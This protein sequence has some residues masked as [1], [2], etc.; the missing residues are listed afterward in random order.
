MFKISFVSTVSTLIFLCTLNLA[1]AEPIEQRFLNKGVTAKVGGYRPLRAEMDADPELAKKLPEN[2]ESPKFGQIKIGEQRWLFVL[3]EPEE[4]AAKLFIDTNHDG[5]LTNDP[6]P[7]WASRAQGELTMYSGSGEV[8]LS[9][10]QVG[11]LGIYRFDPSDKRREMLKNT[12]MYYLDFGYEYRFQLDGKEHTTFVSGV[13]ASSA[14]LPVNRDENPTISRRYELATIGEPFNFT[15]TT[16]TFELNEGQLSLKKNADEIPQQPLPPD[17]RVGQPAIEFTAK[18]LSGEDVKFP[19][20]F[21][22]GIVM[23][24]FWATW[25]GPC[26]AEIPNVKKAYEQSHQDGFEIL[27]ISFDSEGTEK[28]VKEFLEEHELPWQQIYEGKGWD[29]SFADLYD[30]SGIPFVLLVDGDT[31]AILATER[32]LRGK[33]V[34]EFIAEQVKLKKKRLA[35]ATAKGAD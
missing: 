2:L 32:S 29:T 10:G 9:Q 34:A 35:E 11:H 13:P 18:T 23:L 5:D 19:Q 25:C 6:A 3:D 17:L 24:D 27:G 7:V 26:I 8:E 4:G 33:G 21:S 20:S 15:G 14:R 22:G 31:G 16:Y 28:K 1:G 30:V 12:L